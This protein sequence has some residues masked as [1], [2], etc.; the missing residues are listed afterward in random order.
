MKD[1][2]TPH[3]Q[4]LLE[5]K[6]HLLLKVR[7]AVACDRTDLLEELESELHE[8]NYAIRQEMNNNIKTNIK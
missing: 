1:P 7:A 6:R 4:L 5:Q 8:L 2:F 3:Q